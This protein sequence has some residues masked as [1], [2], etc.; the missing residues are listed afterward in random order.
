[1][2]TEA[3]FCNEHPDLTGLFLREIYTLSASHF[4]HPETPKNDRRQTINF[5]LKL[6]HKPPQQQK[7]LQYDNIH[8][9]P[10]DCVS[11][12]G[13]TLNAY[14]LVCWGGIC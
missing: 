9:K 13:R 14:M 12:N 5:S 11:P 10:W 6:P 3:L 8:K 1:M 2:A 4:V 7:Y